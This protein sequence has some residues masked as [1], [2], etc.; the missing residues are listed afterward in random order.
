MTI[1]NHSLKKVLMDTYPNIGL[2]DSKFPT[3]FTKKHWHS[4]SNRKRVVEEIAARL[5]IDPLIP[6][7]WY[8]VTVEAFRNQQVCVVSHCVSFK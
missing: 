6:E 2:I 5:S 7:N 3:I 1:Y 8:N 4:L